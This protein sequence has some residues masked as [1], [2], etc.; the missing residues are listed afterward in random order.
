M[1]SARPQPRPSLRVCLTCLA[2]SLSLLD[3]AERP[4]EE[5]EVNDAVARCRDPE[6]V[7]GEL[8]TDILEEQHVKMPFAMSL[9][10]GCMQAVSS[11]HGVVLLGGMPTVTDETFG[12]TRCFQTEAVP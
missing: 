4:C 8:T 1:V 5:T 11:V 10:L 7:F 2:R 3:K 6:N 9:L 12:C